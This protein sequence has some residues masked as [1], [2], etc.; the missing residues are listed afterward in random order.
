MKKWYKVVSYPDASRHEVN[1]YYKSSAHEAICAV[2]SLDTLQPSVS[3]ATPEEIASID[4]V[5]RGLTEASL[6]RL[7]EEV[8]RRGFKVVQS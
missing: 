2:Y 7:F 5:R 6:E 3:E 1:F 4:P 8:N